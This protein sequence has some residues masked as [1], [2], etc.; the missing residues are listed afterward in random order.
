M[1]IAFGILTSRWRIFQKPIRAAVSN[2]EECIMACLTRQNYLR[3]TGNPF[4]SASGFI[5]S[6]DDCRIIISGIWRSSIDDRPDESE[7]IIIERMQL[8]CGIT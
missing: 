8:R 7:A 2:V 3:Q 1:Q 5:N 6:A 4:Y